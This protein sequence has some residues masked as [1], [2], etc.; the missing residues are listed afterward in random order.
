M[1]LIHLHCR[2]RFQCYIISF[3]TNVF[4]IIEYALDIVIMA[5]FT[6]LRSMFYLDKHELIRLKFN[7]KLN[8]VGVSV[9][10]LKLK[11]NLK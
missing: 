5:R 11:A 4:F 7:P 9:F 6:I 1:S 8:F 10:P 3:I 2:H